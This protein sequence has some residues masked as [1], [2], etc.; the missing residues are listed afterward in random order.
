MD[1]IDFGKS[2]VCTTGPE[3]APQ[4][5]VESYC[6]IIDEENGTQ[7]GYYQ[8]ASCKSEHTFAEKDLFQDPN[9]DFLPVFSQEDIVFF[10][11]HALC[12]PDYIEPRRA[13]YIEYRKAKDVWGGH[14][15]VIKKASSVQVL[16]DNA[17]V[18]QTALKGLPVVGRTE[19][20]NDNTKMRAI[21]EYP[22]KTLNANEGKS[23]Y[24]VDTGPVLFPDL[25]NRYDRNIEA[26]SLAFVAFNTP[27]FSD[28]VIEGPT[29]IIENGKEIT[30]VYHYS[31]IKSDIPAKNSLFCINE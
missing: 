19:I 29:P 22:V 2:F 25:T 23:I 24:Q 6:K 1:C 3:N 31:G 13:N 17:K 4:F 15:F 16:D 11:R 9:Y 7:D 28:F 12:N 20:W 30:R 14:R 21:I 18:V 10:R 8:C 26:L 27:H 5:W